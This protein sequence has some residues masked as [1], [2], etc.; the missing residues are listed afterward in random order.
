MMPYVLAY[1]YTGLTLALLLGLY[2]LYIGPTTLD[3]ILSYDIVCICVVGMVILFSIQDHTIYFLEIL[4]IF[5]LL[6][7]CS[8]IAFMDYLFENRSEEEKR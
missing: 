2:R 6:G 1:C 4:L 3:R 8:T 5:C 7:F